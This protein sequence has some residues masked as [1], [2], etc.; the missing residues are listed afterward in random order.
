MKPDVINDLAKE[1]ERQQLR[2][3]LKIVIFIILLIVH[4]PLAEAAH[5]ERA[6]LKTFKEKKLILFTD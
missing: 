2:V 3:C 5:G 1:K 6:I 4:K